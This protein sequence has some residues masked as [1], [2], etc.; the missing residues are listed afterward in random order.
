M[1]KKL[2]QI[3]TTGPDE[4]QLLKIA[5]GDYRIVVSGEETDGAFA[6]IEMT[7][8]PGAGPNPHSHTAINES[9]FVIEGELSFQTEAGKYLGKKNALINIPTGGMVHG[10]KNLTDKPAKVLCTVMP[11]GLE[12]FFRDMEEVM[13]NPPASEVGLKEKIQVIA[14]KHGQKLYPKDYF[15]QNM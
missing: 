1:N 7:V 2:K 15:D 13:T 5:G 4:G 8:P 6:V 14:E 10:F 11:A 9:F 3:L 12:N